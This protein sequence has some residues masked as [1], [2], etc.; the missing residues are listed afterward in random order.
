MRIS[1]SNPPATAGRLPRLVSFVVLVIILGCHHEP[2]SCVKVS[3]KVTFEDGSLIPADRIHLVFLSQVPPIDQKTPPKAGTAEADGK[4]GT[5]NLATT[6]AY[7]D[8]IIAGEHKVLIQ[9]YRNGQLAHDLVADEYS[10]ASKTPLRVQSSQAPFDL[11]VPKP[12]A[13]SRP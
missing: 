13:F 3:G 9:C 5:F 2:Y 12:T 11:K 10:T 6:F 1:H 4:T 7:G 8:G